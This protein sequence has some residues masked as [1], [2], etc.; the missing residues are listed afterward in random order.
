MTTLTRLERAAMRHDESPSQKHLNELI[1][2]GNAHAEWIR[3]NQ[4]LLRQA[5]RLASYHQ[6][7]LD[8]QI[9]EHLRGW[10][11]DL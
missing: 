4:D 3:R 8:R 1:A 9:R 7:S 2:A 5:Q 11:A 6:P 10:A